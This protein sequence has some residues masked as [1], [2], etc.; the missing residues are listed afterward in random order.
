MA[1]IVIT[2]DDSLAPL[3]L[4]GPTQRVLQVETLTLWRDDHTK[5]EFDRPGVRSSIHLNAHVELCEEIGRGATGQVYAARVTETGETIAV[6]KIAL[7]RFGLSFR[8]Y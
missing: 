6:K 8:S 4:T 2:S 1:D 3:S 7:V 5:L